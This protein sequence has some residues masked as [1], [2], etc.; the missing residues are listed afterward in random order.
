MASRHLLRSLPGHVAF[1][2]SMLVGATATDTAVY[3]YFY[4][5]WG[6]GATNAAAYLIPPVLVVTVC[7]IATR[8][9]RTGGLVC[10]AGGLAAGSWWLWRQAAGGRLSFIVV[11]TAVVFFAPVL[12]MGAL[13]LLEA[14]HRRLLAAEGVLPASGWWRRH[15]RPVL[16]VVVPVLA[17]LLGPARQ[18]PDLLARH[19]DGKRGARTIAGNGVTLTWAPQGPGWNQLQPDGAYPSWDAIASYGGTGAGLCGHL[20]EDGSS[21]VAAPVRAWRLPTSREVIGSL[22]RGGTNA[23][24]AWDGR[25]DH[26]TC[27]RPPD[28]ET[29]LW[30]PDQPPI[31][32]LTSDAAGEPFVL[33]VNYTGGITPLRRL[34][35][36]RG[37]GYRCVRDSAPR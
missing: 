1:L 37:V 34:S 14:R 6:Q 15:H 22:T 29:P 4:E 9:P 5:G 16:V 33:G 3:S 28:K 21:L 8:W 11:Q 19:D 27:T 13:F 30:A 32:Y 10:L 2:L 18:L 35:A 36:G 25:E 17:L 31:Y 12:A 23:G 24:C 7:A 20:S 26:A